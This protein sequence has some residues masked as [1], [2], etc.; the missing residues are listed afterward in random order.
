MSRKMMWEEAPEVEALAE[1]L[2][3]A[4]HPHLQEC[5]FRYIFRSRHLR[6][7]RRSIWACVILMSGRQQYLTG[8]DIVMEVGEDIWN[9]LN[10]HEKRALVD[11]ELCHCVENGEG[12]F[13][14]TP[15]DVEEFIDIMARYGA[16]RDDRKEF[17]R[18]AN[19]FEKG[20]N[21]SES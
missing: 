11:H 21:A 5:R 15:H 14:L 10:D 17:V 16:W 4:Y 7:G 12:G 19:D 3:A 6:D 20:V 18:A 9:S 1:E 2:I 8:C 13:A